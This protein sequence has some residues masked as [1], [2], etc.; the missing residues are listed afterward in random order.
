ME[1]WER[2]KARLFFALWPDAAVRG[3]IAAQRPAVG[4]SVA[5]E[6]L[7]LTLLFLGSVDVEQSRRLREAA[8][9]VIVPP[10]ELRLV[11][12]DY[13]SRSRVA[14]LGLD[15]APPALLSLHR[16]LKAAAQKVGLALESRR[17]RPHVTL[18]RD[19][20]TIAPR[21][22]DPIHWTV[23]DFCLA[24]SVLRPKGSQ[25]LVRQRWPLR[26]EV[27]PAVGGAGATVE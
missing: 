26:T 1:G 20:A 11:R 21:P 22:I 13:W 15:E 8:A 10:F 23:T 17:Y 3:R 2:R 12:L 16:Q 7:H 18:A 19:A 5:E 27:G 4:R 25:Y 9:T 24:E 6:N 14:W